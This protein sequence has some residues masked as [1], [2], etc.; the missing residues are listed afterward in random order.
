METFTN[1]TGGLLTGAVDG[2][3]AATGAVADVA[4]NAGSTAVNA[5]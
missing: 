4:S 1:T 5:A 3:T 2:V